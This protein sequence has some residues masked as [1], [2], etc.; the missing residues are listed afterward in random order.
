MADHR[1]R[2]I[3]CRQRLPRSGGILQN[4]PKHG[5]LFV[6]EL[7]VRLDLVPIHG[8]LLNGV[9]QLREDPAFHGSEEVAVEVV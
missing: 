9:G 5:P 4:D 1:T 6:R 2:I 7:V 8:V 3:I